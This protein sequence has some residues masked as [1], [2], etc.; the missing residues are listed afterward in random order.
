[1][2]IEKICNK[3]SVK[4]VLLQRNTLFRPH[5]IPIKRNQQFEHLEKIRFLNKR[6]ML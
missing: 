3:L 5:I 6:M 2:C 1:M 4:E